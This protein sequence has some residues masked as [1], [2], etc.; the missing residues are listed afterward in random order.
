MK[1]IC[2]SC[3]GCGLCEYLCSNNA[4]KLIENKYGID[5]AWIDENKCINC[6]LCIKKCPE[7]NNIEKTYPIKCYVA[8]AKDSNIYNSTTS[9]GISTLLAEY[10]IKCS[11]V[12]YGASFNRNKMVEHIRID[13]IKDLEFIK[14]SKY[15]Q[16]SITNVF[17]QIRNDLDKKKDIL[18][19]GTPCQCAAIKRSFPKAENI[20]Y[21]DLICHGVPP[22]KY[23]KEYLMSFG[24]LNKDD[25]NVSFRN[26]RYWLTIFKNKKI[27]YKKR[28][29]QDPYFY[30]FMYNYLTRENCF[31]CQFSNI[32]RCSDITIGDFWGLHKDNDECIPEFVSCV[33]INTIKGN[34]TFSKIKN[35]CYFQE[36]DIKEA[37]LGNANLQH[38]S[39]RPKKKDAFNKNYQKYGLIGAMKKVGIYNNICINSIMNLLLIPYRL[40]KYGRNYKKL[41]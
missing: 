4:I 18:F 38:P 25:I 33:L 36:R 9:G 12:I 23:L 31:H 16:S 27:V 34:E 8:W 22:K 32:K 10:F 40:V 19:I 20:L 15:V 21:V 14:G 3:T 26:K 35:D 39:K 28:Y 1:L 29:N 37:L 5:E 30:G 24:F 41:L 11:G 2:N 7:L 17:D 6:N 13:T